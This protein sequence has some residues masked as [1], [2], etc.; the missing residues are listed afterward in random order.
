[1]QKRA[2]NGHAV[3]QSVIFNISPMDTWALTNLKRKKVTN[4]THQWLTDSLVDAT[5][6]NAHVEGD[7]ASFVTATT[8]VLN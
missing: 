4:T 3:T 5:A 7:D 2:L 6:G 1:M 8:A